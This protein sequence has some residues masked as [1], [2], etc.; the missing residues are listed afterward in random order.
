MTCHRPSLTWTFIYLRISRLLRSILYHRPT[1]Y[2][3]FFDWP[4]FGIF[5]FLYYPWS[6]SYFQ[7]SLQISS[8]HFMPRLLM[9]GFHLRPNLPSVTDILTEGLYAAWD[10]IV[11]FMKSRTIRSIYL[12]RKC[13]SIQRVPSASSG[14]YLESVFVQT[15]L[16]IKLNNSWYFRKPS[17]FR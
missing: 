5:V 6:F 4:F 9:A 15:T 13:C 10:Y 7:L 17:P 16:I 1:P 14:G 3:S 8:N 12:I 2:V 11:D